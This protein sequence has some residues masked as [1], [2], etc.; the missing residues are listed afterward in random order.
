MGQANMELGVQQSRYQKSSLMV[1]FPLYVPMA[2]PLRSGDSC[3]VCVRC[4]FPSSIRLHMRD[5]SDHS[6]S[7]PK[8]VYSVAGGNL[9]RDLSPGRTG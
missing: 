7:S 1:K 2:I 6:Q 5:Y 3:F 9:G 8:H 4:V